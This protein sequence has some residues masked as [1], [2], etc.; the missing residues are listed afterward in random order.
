MLSDSVVKP[1]PRPEPQPAAQPT[2]VFPQTREFHT[3]KRT[4]R[5]ELKMVECGTVPVDRYNFKDIPL[6][7]LL[8]LIQSPT[9]EEH[10]TVKRYLHNSDF[11][12]YLFI[13]KRRCSHN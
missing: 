4:V 9:V 8:V 10:K 1:K 13:F 6:D 5:Q 7:I 12:I 3:L 2:E 11:F